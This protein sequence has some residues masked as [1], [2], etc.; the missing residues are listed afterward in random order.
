MESG[1]ETCGVTET[2]S[3]VTRTD[4]IYRRC[5]QMCFFGELDVDFAEKKYGVQLTIYTITRTP[6]S[7]VP[8]S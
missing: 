5:F 6:R 8:V 4:T 1:Q 3:E 7:R 2:A